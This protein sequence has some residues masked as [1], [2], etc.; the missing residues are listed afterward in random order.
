MFTDRDVPFSEVWPVLAA[1]TVAF[2]VLAYL[3]R[4]RFLR[5]RPASASVREAAVSALA[6]TRSEIGS[7]KLIAISMGAILG[8]LAVAVQALSL[9]GKMDSKS[10]SSFIGLVLMV[11]VFN[12]MILWLKWRRKLRPRRDRLSSIMN[13]LD[14]N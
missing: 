7:L 1:Q 2:T 11:A 10:V 4:T 12:A 6:E 13:D 5:A 8:L 9:S 14:T 3:L